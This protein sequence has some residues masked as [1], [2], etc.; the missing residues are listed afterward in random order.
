MI[1]VE[2]TGEGEG[3]GD[4]DGLGDGAGDGLGAGVGVAGTIATH[5][6]TID[7]TTANANVRNND[8]NPGLRSND[9]PEEVPLGQMLATSLAREPISS[10]H[11]VPALRS[12]LPA[13]LPERGAA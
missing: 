7:A 11:A 1:A 6:Q 2:S 5:A 3:P 13:A 8:P 12:P 9:P 10:P 4:G